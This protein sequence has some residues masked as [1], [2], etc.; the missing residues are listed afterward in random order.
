MA[1]LGDLQ[2]GSGGLIGLLNSPTMAL[3]AG[4]LDP[5]GT[6]G[7]FGASLNRGL[8]NSFAAQRQQM[9]L[10]IQKQQL[11]QAAAKAAQQKQARQMFQQGLGTRPTQFQ[12]DTFPGEDPANLSGQP[13]LGLLNRGTGA[14]AD[15]TITTDEL[16][17]LAL[18]QLSIGNVAGVNS[19]LGYINASTPQTKTELALAAADGDK[20]AQEALRI[21]NGTET[22]KPLSHIAKINADLANGLITQEQANTMINAVGRSPGFKEQYM[23]PILLKMQRGEPLTEGEEQVQ[24]FFKTVDPFDQIIKAAMRGSTDSNEAQLLQ[25]A[26]DAIAQ[27]KDRGAVE[28]VLRDRGID[29]AKLNTGGMVNR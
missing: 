26:R 4:L 7:N 27:G 5:R 13:T 18:D 1:L 12:P 28:Q 10:D 15:G 6:Y 19:V 22:I 11:A 25:Q 14:L 29:P 3:A 21:L 17:G 2:R 8:Q 24:D 23:A 20:T 9:I 16:R